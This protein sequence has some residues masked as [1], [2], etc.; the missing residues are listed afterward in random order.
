MATGVNVAVD[1]RWLYKSKF[2][3]TLS[4]SSKRTPTVQWV[5]VSSIVHNFIR[6]PQVRQWSQSK[7]RNPNLK[8]AQYL[9]VIFWV[10]IIQNE[11]IIYFRIDGRVFIKFD[12]EFLIWLN[13]DYCPCQISVLC[14]CLVIVVFWQR[15]IILLWHVWSQFYYCGRICSVIQIIRLL[16]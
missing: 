3:V 6:N 5:W 12:K 10:E 4:V 16:K 2:W 7:H 8:F 15:G 14:L 13:I 11:S 1:H 9:Y